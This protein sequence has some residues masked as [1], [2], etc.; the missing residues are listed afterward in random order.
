MCHKQHIARRVSKSFRAR[1][2]CCQSSHFLTDFI[3]GIGFN[4]SRG[5][6]LLMVTNTSSWCILL[7]QSSS[8]YGA[9]GP[10]NSTICWQGQSEYIPP[11][12][13]NLSRSCMNFWE[14]Y[15]ILLQSLHDGNIYTYCARTIQ[16]SHLYDRDIPFTMTSSGSLLSEQASGVDATLHSSQTLSNVVSPVPSC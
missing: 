5:G 7:G 16:L 13:F 14:L 9:S 10:K 6:L 4:R 2:Y 11:F 12:T 8:S 15:V 1:G 3:L